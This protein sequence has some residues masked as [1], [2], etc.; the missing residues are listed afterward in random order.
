MGGQILFVYNI[1]YDAEEKTLW[2]LFAPLGTVTK[3]NVIMDHV[4]NQCKG[5]GFVTMKHLHE[6]EGAILALNGAMYNN[7]R[8]SVSFKSWQTGQRCSKCLANLMCII[9]FFFFFSYFSFRN[10]SQV[11]FGFFNITR[12][13]KHFLFGEISKVW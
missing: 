2:Q 5:Y 11:L 10:G 9:F 7:R 1:G 3:V 8:L 4:R 12:H 13:G 6:A